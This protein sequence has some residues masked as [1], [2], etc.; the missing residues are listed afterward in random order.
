MNSWFMSWL[1]LSLSG[2]ILALCILVATPWMRGRISHSWQY[3]IW[4]IVI[5]RLLLP[6]APGVNGVTEL[7][8][9]ASR[10]WQAAVQAPNRESVPAPGAAPDTGR[11]ANTQ[12]APAQIEGG[13]PAE[14]PAA[15]SLK[16]QASSAPSTA[17]YRR[18]TGN[19]WIVWLAG[20]G[21]MLGWKSMAYRRFY[22]L[23]NQGSRPEEDPLVAAVL[24]QCLMELD[25]SAP[26]AVRRS[27]LV[28]TPLL[29][30]LGRPGIVLPEGRFDRDELRHIF[31]HELTHC[32]RL[33]LPVKWLVQ[34]GV[35]LHWFNPAV[36]FVARQLDRLCELACDEAVI[37][38]MSPAEKQGYGQTLLA[39]ASSPAGRPAMMWG[40][41][42]REGQALK[43]RLV[44]IMKS[45]TGK[46]STRLAV[47]LL[48]AV[49]CGAFFIGYVKQREHT[50]YAYDFAQFSIHQVQ[51]GERFSDV[52]T[53]RFI[54]TD[55]GGDQGISG[56]YQY[57]AEQIKLRY[58]TDGRITAIHGNVY[59]S[60]FML[61]YFKMEETEIGF[62]RVVTQMSEVRNILGSSDGQWY[63]RTQQLK[64]ARYVDSQ[65]GIAVTFVYSDTDDR[66]VWV[67]S[68]YTS[69]PPDVVRSI[70][71]LSSIAALKTQYVGE[72]SKVS[73][74]AGRLPVPHYNFMQRFIALQTSEQPYGLTMYYEP[75]SNAMAAPAGNYGIPLNDSSARFGK[76]MRANALVL[77][78]MIDN[79]DQVTFA[80]RPSASGNE[81]DQAAYPVSYSFLRSDFAAYGNLG[82]LANDLEQLEKLLLNWP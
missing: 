6:V 60:G 81:L 54:E 24:N 31:L 19:L 72:A 9:H 5:V 22:R 18:L 35:C 10:I 56:S 66:L 20:A 67:L 58:G 1:S 68:D 55:H 74:M 34:L 49:A 61:P 8:K 16:A 62:S 21:A 46:N 3:Y 14:E 41:M 32:K 79:L 71:P 29:I 27:S 2:T 69:D 82:A 25:I 47:L 70:Y 38:N 78:S 52:D 73:Q 80:F 28:R 36:Y 77:F 17:P 65:N 42:S 40:A 48:A 75:A 64:S 59:E 44:A 43:E 11:P 7:T 30:G 33:D 45:S 63:D 53:S 15:S 4:L 37:R 50:A 23:L 76:I 39:L 51:L 57:T 12:T 13:N 26:I